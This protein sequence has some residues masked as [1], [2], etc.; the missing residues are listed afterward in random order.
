MVEVRYIP[1]RWRELADT[2]AELAA[3]GKGI[4]AL[5]ESN[6]TC[7]KRFEAV[8]AES[9]PETR[10]QY[11]CLLLG[12][13]GI[14]EHISGAILYDETLRQA[15]DQGTPLP[16]MMSR[17]GIVPGIKV[18]TGAKPLAG[19][20]G[21]QVTEGL[22]GLRER[23]QEYRELGARF[24]K[25]RAVIRIGEGMP[26]RQCLNANTHALARYSALCQ[27]AGLVPIVEPEVLL[28]GDH[29]LDRCEQATEEVLRALFQ[30]LWEQNVLLEGAILKSSMVVPGKDS[31]Q[32]VAPE[33]VADRTVVTLLRSVPAAL[34]AV[35][36]LSGG[37]SERQATMHLDAMNRRWGN[38]APWRLTFSYARALQQP[39][40]E[41]WRGDAARTA[42]AQQAFAERA[43]LNG[44][45]SEGCYDPAMDDAA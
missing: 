24:A 39:A 27:E 14:A 33:T 31:G 28:E 6:A 23:L 12:A 34:G 17:A 45:A 5:D 18:D 10:R 38:R 13:P 37:Q 20:P 4:V 40:L 8:G 25:W 2:V 32:Q 35:V 1:T 9:T 36:F 44:L 21:E 26:S 30:Q 41:I 29:D 43:R 15:D 11:R 3:P 19:A 16:E 42:E 22:D 7:T